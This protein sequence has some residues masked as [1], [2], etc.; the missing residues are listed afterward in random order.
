MFMI[1]VLLCFL[2]GCSGNP[3]PS[4]T[5][6]EDNFRAN[7]AHF[8]ELLS[9][10]NEDS[11]VV[12]ISKRSAFLGSGADPRLPTERLDRYR[13]L[14][15]LLKLDAGVHRQDENTIRFVASSVENIFSGYS[16]KFY[17]YSTVEP[18][19]LVE[20]LDEVIKTKPG[21]HPPVFKKLYGNWYLGYESW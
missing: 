9:M 2:V 12:R 11:R 1:L 7:E 20:S 5:T 21:K 13:E 3:H 18:S 10:L 17:L 16:S 4:D 6:L 19:P 14:F 15:R 8:E